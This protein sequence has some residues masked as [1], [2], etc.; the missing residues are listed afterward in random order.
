MNIA[1][2]LLPKKDVIHLN[3]NS[4]MRQALERMKY[5]RYTSVPI[6]DD[7][8][9]YVGVL[10]EGDLLW[11][12]KNSPGLTFMNT[13]K[14]SLKDIE[15]HTFNNPVNVDAQME[16]LFSYATEQNFVSV[17]DDNGIFIGIVR[18]SEIIKYCLNLINSPHYFPTFKMK[19]RSSERS[20]SLT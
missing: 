5:H 15:R 10:T 9:K 11:K 20:L 18:R 1:F 16:D 8:G 3:I 19:D 2:F 4:T 12:M 6:I 13:Q 17:V 7:D 14:I